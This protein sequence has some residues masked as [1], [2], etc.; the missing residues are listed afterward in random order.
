MRKFLLRRPSPALIVASL[1]LFV[2]LGGG[3]YAAFKLPKN[4]VGSKQIKNGAVVNSKLAN[5]SVGTA[6]LRNNSVTSSKI[7][8][9]GLTVP[10]ALHANAADTA[11]SATTAANAIKVNGRNV[12]CA[13]GTVQ[14]LGQCFE[15]S[16]RAAADV[17]TASDTCK[18]AGGY[19]GDGFQLRSGRG[20][21]PLT[22]DA[23][24]EWIS[25]FYVNGATSTAETIANGGGFLNVGTLTTHPFR[26]VFP[27]VGGPGTVSATSH[28]ASHA[29][30]AN[31]AS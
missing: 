30:Q 31:G 10:N 7:N 22:L 18:A 15:T 1:A 12:G 28:A 24:G 11:T 17:F 6:K 19:L 26:C 13:A 4:S 20:G 3:A 21:T 27:L 5:N 9:S 14:F 16:T 23:T 8:T 25:L 29:T 2:A